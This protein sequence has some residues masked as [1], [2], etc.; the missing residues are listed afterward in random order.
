MQG[1]ASRPNSKSREDPSLFFCLLNHNSPERGSAG[2][3]EATAIERACR[4]SPPRVEVQG[5]R[6]NLWWTEAYPFY[7]QNALATVSSAGT[8]L[9]SGPEGFAFGADTLPRDDA[10]LS[11]AFERD[12]SITFSA[13]DQP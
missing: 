9:T 1:S 11:G 4:P 8:D 10:R 6:G 2:R 12:R 3:G 13:H 5:R 7:K